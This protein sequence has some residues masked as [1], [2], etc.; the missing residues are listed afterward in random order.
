[1][2]GYNRRELVI[3]GGVLSTACTAAPATI[4]E[5]SGAEGHAFPLLDDWIRITIGTEAEVARTIV[6]LQTLLSSSVKVP[7]P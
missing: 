2:A 6:T 1:M 7:R 5:A 3:A 4:R